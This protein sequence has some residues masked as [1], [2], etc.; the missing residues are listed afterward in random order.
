MDELNEKFFSN[1]TKIE[2]KMENDERA[3]KMLRLKKYKCSNKECRKELSEKKCSMGN[4]MI[5]IC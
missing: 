5:L 4:H 1:P 3:L 2:E